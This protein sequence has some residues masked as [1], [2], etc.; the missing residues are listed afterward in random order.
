MQK[1]LNALKC[2][3]CRNILSSPVTLPCG[4]TI[5]QEHTRVA[6]EH[7]ICLECGCRHENKGEFAAN[8]A[9]TDMIEAQ[10]SSFDFGPRYKECVKLCETLRE[11]LEKNELAVN[12]VNY[13]IHDSIEQ[14]RNKVL[15]KSEQLK[16]KVDEITQELL[17]DLANY[18]NE[19]KE[20]RHS[21]LVFVDEIKR[22]N[23]AAKKSYEKWTNELNELKVDDEKWKRIKEESDKALADSCEKLKDLERELMNG[24]D[25]KKVLVSFFEKEHINSAFNSVRSFFFQTRFIFFYLD[26]FDLF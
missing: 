6:D 16:L 7:I 12:D 5:C 14:L 26:Y 8:K 25:K 20:K 17:D 19:C 3:N 21:K 23:N 10:L 13:F 15:L 2:A 4:H 22:Q 18:E 9:L 24:F 1:I 11:Q